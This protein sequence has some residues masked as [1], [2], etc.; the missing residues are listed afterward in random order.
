MLS[1]D[2]KMAQQQFVIYEQLKKSWVEAVAD[3]GGTSL[4]S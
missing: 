2:N 3:P 4:K 1:F